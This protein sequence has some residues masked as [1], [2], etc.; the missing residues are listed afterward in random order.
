MSLKRLKTLIDLLQPTGDSLEIGTG[1]A[2]PYL[3][4]FALKSLTTIDS[5]VKL[6]GVFDAILIDNSDL[7]CAGKA[8]PALQTGKE[9]LTLVKETFPD[10]HTIQY[11]DQDIEDCWK[12]AGSKDLATFSSFLSELK[13]AGQISKTQYDE[14]IQTYRLTP[15]ESPPPP[16]DL[17]FPLVIEC[18]QHHMRKGSRLACFFRGSSYD[19]P[20]WFDQIITNPSLDVAETSFDDYSVVVIEK[21]C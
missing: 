1:T 16:S 4:T 17:L 7:P 2:T 14:A 18:I 8:K 12:A 11:T 6:S 21:M 5:P 20:R 3:Q 10:L 9:I 13:K 15:T 19:D